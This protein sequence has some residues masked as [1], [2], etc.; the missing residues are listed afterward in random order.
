MV[1]SQDP[2]IQFRENEDMEDWLNRLD[3][4]K[5][6]LVRSYRFLLSVTTG[7]DGS[8]EPAENPEEVASRGHV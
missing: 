3:D 7:T 1:I 2:K 4:V 5:Q 6:E 8:A